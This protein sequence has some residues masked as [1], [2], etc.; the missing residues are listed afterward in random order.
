MSGARHIGT[1]ILA[2]FRLVGAVLTLPVTA[3]ETVEAV[4]TAVPRAVTGD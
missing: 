3:A 4:A 2:P 1:G